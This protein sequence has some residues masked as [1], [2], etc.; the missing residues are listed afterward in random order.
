MSHSPKHH[1][2]SCPMRIEIAVDQTGTVLDVTSERPDPFHHNS[3]TPLRITDIISVPG[4]DMSADELLAALCRDPW[5]VQVDLPSGP[6][7]A[8]ATARRKRRWFGKGAA[9]IVTLNIADV[10]VAGATGYSAHC[11]GLAASIDRDMG[12]VKFDGNGT[13][14]WANDVFLSTQNLRPD[15][16]IGQDQTVLFHHDDAHSTFHRRFWKGLQNGTPYAGLKRLVDVGGTPTWFRVN[17]LPSQGGGGQTGTIFMIGQVADQEVR[18]QRDAQGQIRALNSSQAVIEFDNSGTILSANDVFLEV[19]GYQG[20]GVAGQ[21]H[22]IFIDFHSTPEAEYDAFWANLRRG[23]FASGQ[24]PRIRKDGQRV[25][26]QATYNPILDDDGR[27]I[28]VVKFA[29]DITSQV[30][31]NRLAQGKLEALDRSTAVIQFEP[32]GTILDANDNFVSALKYGAAAEIIGKHHSIFV[33]GAYA[34]S[35]DYKKFWDALRLGNFQSGEFQRCGRDGSAVWI[36][37]SYN[38]ILDEQGNVERIV[39]FATDITKNREQSARHQTQIEAID[40]TQAVITFNLDGIVETVNDN[41]LDALGFARSD[42][43]GSHHATFVHPE[44][45]DSQAY[46]DFWADLR[47]G[48]FKSGEFKRR[49][50]DGRDVWI[51]G[52]YNPI[53]NAAGELVGVYKYATDITREV[54]DRER[55]E[56]LS[57]VTDE[58]ANSVVIT[59]KQGRIEYTNR[60]FENLT[61]FKLEEV[62]GKKPGDVLQGPNTDPET[63]R[64]IRKNLA[65]NTPFY[66]EILNYSR[67]GK[68]YWISLAI[69]PVFDANG[70]V[71]RFVSIQSNIDATKR[72]SLEFTRTLEAI[73]STSAISEWDADGKIINKNAF[74]EGLGASDVSMPSILEAGDRACVKSGER[75]RRRVEWGCSDGEK[76]T[77]DAVFNAV[78]DDSGQLTKVLMFG[79]NITERDNLINGAMTAI[80]DSTN[81]IQEMVSSIEDFGN[82]TRNLSLNASVEA[83][84]AG[85]SGKGFAVVAGEVR[86]LADKATE[87]AREIALLLDESRMRAA[88]LNADTDEVKKWTQAED[89]AKAAGSSVV[90]ADT[91]LAS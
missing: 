11:T 6:C 48:Q 55:I 29:T 9:C 88:E 90:V 32:D 86:I 63:I 5:V 8:P 28:K 25:W 57:L 87:A 71:E 83:S 60:G 59:D 79:I 44:Y 10:A 23:E 72:K 36:Q 49:H 27:V 3:A 80:Q 13:I 64:R 45:R 77:F 2:K 1:Y 12:V 75:L 40:K 16:I 69:N 37:A 38:P 61:G 54:V 17:F 42:V 53:Q 89:E 34:A 4:H 24:F 35:D 41:F 33:D 66:E 20:T 70:N 46:L 30:E 51:R 19:M 67:T 18:S 31:A 47:G 22:R 82:Q 65:E 58:T 85:E 52:V 73:S 26:I 78:L 43:L 39:K 84:R 62:V 76:L 91:R 15:D 74:L 50:R 56:L 68:P 81:R 14:L 21:H 7:D